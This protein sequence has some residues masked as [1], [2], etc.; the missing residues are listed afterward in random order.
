MVALKIVAEEEAA[1]NKKSNLNFLAP[2]RAKV[3][4]QDTK[5]KTKERLVSEMGKKTTVTGKV[6]RPKLQL[7][8]SRFIRLGK[9]FRIWIK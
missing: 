9:S 4:A 8:V 5:E 3:S 6:I 2:K 7:V 1:L